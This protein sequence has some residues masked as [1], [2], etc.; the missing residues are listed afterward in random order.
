MPRLRIASGL[1]P[2]LLTAGLLTLAAG[3]LARADEAPS[4]SALA[5]PLA[6]AMHA[7]DVDEHLGND[8]ER[9]LQFT[10][11]TGKKVTLGDYFDGKRP[12]LLT[13]NYFRCPVLCNVQLNELTEALRTF[14]WV[15]GDEHFRIGIG[16]PSRSG[17]RRRWESI[18]RRK[19]A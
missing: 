4:R 6:P 7:V 5:Q 18:C 14:D 16:R 12:V 9:A 15:P 10:D 3:G 11:H 19:K 17:V 8:L 1:G 13:M 2:C